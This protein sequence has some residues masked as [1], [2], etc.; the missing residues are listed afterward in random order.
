[1][2]KSMII[3]NHDDIKRVTE[4]IEIAENVMRGLNAQIAALMALKRT[5][6]QLISGLKLDRY[7]LKRTPLEEHR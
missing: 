3:T 2:K 6:R 1:M 5:Q 7:W 4:K